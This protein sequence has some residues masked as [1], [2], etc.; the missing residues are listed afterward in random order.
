MKVSKEQIAAWKQ[1]HKDVYRIDVEDKSCYLKR[2]SRQAIGYATV[3]GKDNPVKFNEVL[4]Q[5]C[6]LGGDEEIK[7]DDVLFMS[8]S[9][10]LG[11]LVEVKTAELVKL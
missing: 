4:L 8:V 1:E 7:Q 2:P 5:E 11:E 6:W 10:K 3:A 9:A